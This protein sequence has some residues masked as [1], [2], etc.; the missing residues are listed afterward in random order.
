MD[1]VL[2]SEIKPAPGLRA[3]FEKTQAFHGTAAFLGGFFWD[4]ATLRRIDQ[5]FDNFLLFVYLAFLGFCL[6][7]S[8]RLDRGRGV[9]AWA[10]KRREALQTLVHFFFGGLFSAYLIFY[11]KSAS[12]SKSFLFVLVL[13]GLL[14][15]NEY[16]RKH[17][18]EGRVQLLLYYFC[19][20]SFFLYF[21]PVVTGWM[22]RGV[23]ITAGVLGGLGVWLVF[24]LAGEVASFRFSEAR[25][26]IGIRF[27]DCGALFAV[28]G[29]LYWMG[30][31]PPVPLSLVHAGI[32]HAVVPGNPH[33]RL[34]QEAPPF[35]NLWSHDDRDFEYQPGDEAYCFTAIFAPKGFEL[36]I[37]HRWEWWNEKQGKWEESDRL[38]FRVSGGREGGY[39]GFTTKRKLRPGR[40]RVRVVTGDGDELGVLPLRVRVKSE[41]SRKWKVIEY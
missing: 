21:I 33:Y 22:G 27:A 18:A 14:L 38:P 34:T 35:W 32:Y 4:A 6:V 15:A 1:G 5:L 30:V 28:L 23:F 19:L 25:T 10:T 39:R 7:L 11:F 13:A 3:F 36:S 37:W 40:Y 17:L 12:L 2:A 31:I 20:F 8:I 9:P 29:I 41:V 26:V 16:G 24:R